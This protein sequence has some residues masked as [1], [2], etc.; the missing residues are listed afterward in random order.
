M[1]LR[2]HGVEGLKVAVMYSGGKDSSYAAYAARQ[3]GDEIACLLTCLPKSEESFMFHF[4]NAELTFL[5]AE[6]MRIP[7]ET[8]TTEGVKEL[9]LFDLFQALAG[10]KGKYQ[11]EGVYT[12]GLASRY[13][14][15]RF[16]KICDQLGLKCVNPLWGV[17]PEVHYNRLLELGFK[18]MVVGVSAAGLG[19]E[20]LG[21]ILDREALE[22]LNA[23]SRKFKFNPAF[24]GGEGETFVLNCPLFLKEIVVRNA[25]KH[26]ISSYYYL[27]IE[28][29]E[30]LEKPLKK[31]VG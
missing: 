9:E 11:I 14:K 30:L 18:I 4:P 25:S 12:G 22:E 10:I 20:W 5:Q 31:L 27:K 6:A 1:N 17:E 26:K 23:L 3:T 8:F 7:L 19:E 28:R 2:W 24:E 21:R 29:A 13:Q 16:G 15:D